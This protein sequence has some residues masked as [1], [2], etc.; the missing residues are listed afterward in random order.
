M[1]DAVAVQAE[2]KSEEFNQQIDFYWFQSLAVLSGN[3]ND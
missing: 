1:L 3:E 2:A